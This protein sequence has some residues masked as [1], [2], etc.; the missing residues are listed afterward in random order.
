MHNEMQDAKNFRLCT[1]ASIEKE[2][3]FSMLQPLYANAG[4]DVIRAFAKKETKPSG[5]L[6]VPCCCRWAMPTL[7]HNYTELTFHRTL[8]FKQDMTVGVIASINF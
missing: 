3:I 7:M 1:F 4:Q 2:T 6:S 5:G 8:S